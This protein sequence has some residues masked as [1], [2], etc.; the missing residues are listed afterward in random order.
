MGLVKIADLSNGS[1]A[2]WVLGSFCC[3]VDGL[4]Q[5]TGSSETESV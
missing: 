3:D 5:V 2:G 1:F 4:V